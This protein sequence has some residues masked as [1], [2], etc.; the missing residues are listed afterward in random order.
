MTNALRQGHERRVKYFAKSS[1]SFA[2]DLIFAT[3][4]KCL[5]ARFSLSIGP[6]EWM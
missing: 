4:S 3:R 6:L 5:G 2:V 1:N